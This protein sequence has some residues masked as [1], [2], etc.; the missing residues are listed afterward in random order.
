MKDFLD[1][2]D[3]RVAIPVAFGA[4]AALALG[5][6]L[7]S[8]L[9]AGAGRKSESAVVPVPPSQG[10]YSFAEGYVPGASDPSLADLELLGEAPADLAADEDLHYRVRTVVP[11]D[12]VWDISIEYGVSMDAI[13]SM[14][15]IPRARA[16]RVGMRLK[17]PSVNG[18]LRAAKAGDTPLSL[19]EAF[20]VSPE[21]IVAANRLEGV[22]VA[23]EK[24]R[25]IF[26]PDASLP[27]SEMGERTGDLFRWPYGGRITSWYGWRRDP[28][29]GR[30]VF[31]G[32]LDIAG[33]RGS[34]VRAAMAGTVAQVGFSS[35]LGNYVT[36]RH[37]VGGYSTLYGH[38]DAATVKVGQWVAVGQGIG[39]LG[40]TGYSTGPHVHFA[41]FKY[42]V[43][44]NPVPL[45]Y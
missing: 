12:T 24:G 39:K 26:L 9:V 31:H 19:A 7:L 44:I 27:R 45:L 6:A 37:P 10:G 43:A 25:S 28:F 22:E 4:F 38:L 36:I 29:N 17:I 21:R 32:A 2:V 8:G 35:I 16:L 34:T 40:N 5:A 1:R 41:V 14:N 23:L 3:E 15:D 33:A 13:F 20:G 42:G 30:R 11:G 18:I